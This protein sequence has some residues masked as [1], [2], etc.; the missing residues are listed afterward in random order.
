MIFSEAV[1]VASTE[2]NIS[3]LGSSASSAVFATRWFFFPI[4][5]ATPCGWPE[6]VATTPV[7]IPSGIPFG[8]PAGIPSGMVAGIPFRDSGV[9]PF[10]APMAWPSSYSSSSASS[11]CLGRLRGGSSALSRLAF[12]RSCRDFF[13]TQHLP[14]L[15][16]QLA[17]GETRRRLRVR[18]HDRLERGRRLSDGHRARDRRLE[19]EIFG[20]FL[21]NFRA[22]ALV[23]VLPC[24]VER[25]ERHQKHV[26][27]VRL[28]D[29]GDRTQELPESQEGE[30]AGFDG[31]DRQV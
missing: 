16:R 13:I 25:R 5:G 14:D 9:R 2:T 29:L 27:R 20:E 10:R 15:R 23:Q 1:C 7:G 24:R 31:D 22:N 12:S 8:V 3:E 28:P 21:N 30:H 6:S 4:F 26:G 11:S 17:E 19:D 18:L